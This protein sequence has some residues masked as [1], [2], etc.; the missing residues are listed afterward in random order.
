[1]KYVNYLVY[2]L[3]NLYNYSILTF[4]VLLTLPSMFF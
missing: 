1:M 4:D 3:H 2:K